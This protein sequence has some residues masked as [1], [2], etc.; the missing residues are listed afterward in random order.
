MHYWCD[1][2]TL[3]QYRGVVY[4]PVPAFLLPRLVGHFSAF[5][6]YSRE[7][8]HGVKTEADLRNAAAAK[9]VPIAFAGV[10]SKVKHTPCDRMHRS[11]H[12]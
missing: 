4:V 8:V 10:E 6:S 7:Q 1:R 9:A 2:V 12:D 5:S 3:N 11:T